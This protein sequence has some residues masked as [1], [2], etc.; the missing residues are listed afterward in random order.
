[1]SEE[2]LTDEEYA[3]LAKDFEAYLEERR[4]KEDEGKEETGQPGKIYGFCEDC[5]HHF[6][7]ESEWDK[8]DRCPDCGG[9]G[10]KV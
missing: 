10:K 1:M 5:G 9:T 4:V 3:Q 7:D 8:Y 2:P 6:R